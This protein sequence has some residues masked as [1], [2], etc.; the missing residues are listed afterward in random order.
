M[1]T[2][3]RYAVSKMIQMFLLREL[4]KIYP[5]SETGVIINMLSPGL[6]KTGLTRRLGLTSRAFIGAF[7]ALLAR[8]P[9]MGSRTILHAL[10][11]GEESHGKYLDNCKLTKYV[12]HFEKKE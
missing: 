7:R 5:T 9:E 3:N 10:S 8:T 4:A 6:V 1:L 11:L 12:E 2:S